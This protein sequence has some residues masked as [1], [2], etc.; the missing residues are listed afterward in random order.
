MDMRQVLVDAGK[1]LIHEGF[2]VETW[3]NISAMQSYVACQ[4]LQPKQN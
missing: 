3:S 4:Y 2:T 1:Q